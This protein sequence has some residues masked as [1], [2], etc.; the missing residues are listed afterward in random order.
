MVTN[1]AANNPTGVSGTV[2]QGQGIGTASSFSTATYPPTATGTGTILRADGT[3]WSATTSTYPN[4]NAINT[5][6]YASS[7]NIMSALATVNNG[8]LITSATGVPS[9]LPDGTTGQ[10]LTATTGSPPSWVPPTAT[11]IA[12][13]TGNSGGAES[14]S[15]GNFNFLTT[16]TTIKFVGTA[17]TETMDFSAAASGNLII[18]TSGASASGTGNVGVGESVLNALTSGNMNTCM[19]D[20]AG[21]HLTSSSNSTAIGSGALSTAAGATGTNTALGKNALTTLNGGT[22]ANTSLGFA[23]MNLLATGVSNIGIGDSAGTSYSTS[24]SSNI[25]VGNSGTIGESNVIRLGTQGSG[26]GQ[27][28]TCFIAGTTGVTVANPSVRTVN[29][30]TGQQGNDTTNFT[31]LSTGLQLKGNNAITAPPA[32]FIGEHIRATV[33]QGSPISISNGTPINIT[34]ISLTA[35]VWDVSCIGAINPSGI[36]SYG[37]MSISTT[38]GTVGTNGDNKAEAGASANNSGAELSLIVPAWRLL[39]SATTTVFMV[40]SVNFTTGTCIGWGRL[41]ATRVG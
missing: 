37:S 12:T 40:A 16:N 11:G 20:A 23:C 14:P 19:G 30:S 35:G 32:G 3:N 13:I 38:T 4:T 27:Q 9:I 10:V 6:L 25:V 5:L 18:G 41:S 34:S 7:A 39:L 15:A 24:E 21:Q 31:I 29:T 36:S 8:V 17:A 28:N 26:A 33:G 2:L 1:N 22:G